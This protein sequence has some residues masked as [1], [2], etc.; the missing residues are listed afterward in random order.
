MKLE[1]LEI[2]L[3]DSGIESMVAAPGSFKN[4]YKSVQFISLWGI[5]SVSTEFSQNIIRSMVG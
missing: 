3:G 4:E 2:G 5:V 1:D